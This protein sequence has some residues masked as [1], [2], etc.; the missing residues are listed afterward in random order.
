MFLTPT[1]LA[2]L[3]GYRRPGAQVRW[4]RSRG[5]RHYVNGAGH[6]V[7]ARAGLVGALGRTTEARLATSAGEGEPADRRKE[8]R[9]SEEGLGASGTGATIDPYM[10]TLAEILPLRHQWTPGSGMDG[11]GIY[12]LFRDDEL[13]YVGQSREVQFR[14][15]AHAM[16]RVS[17]GELIPFNLWAA[18]DAPE[19]LLVAI[20]RIYIANFAPP[21]NRHPSQP[22]MTT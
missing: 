2:T 16:K 3:T 13:L 19:E 9:A 21:F 7:V 22:G 14:L 10:F 20:E 6:P 4:L 12:F 5:I 15:R 1:D 17:P 11:P 18:L 8:A